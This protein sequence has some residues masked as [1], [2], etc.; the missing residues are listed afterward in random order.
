MSIKVTYIDRTSQSYKNVDMGVEM[1]LGVVKANWK[2][3]QMSRW[4]RFMKFMKQKEVIEKQTLDG[5]NFR[6]SNFDQMNMDNCTE[7]KEPNILNK[8]QQKLSSGIKKRLTMMPRSPFKDDSL[9]QLVQDSEN[10][11]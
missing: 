5:L 2:P 9:Y 1:N 3:I 8:M 4:I 10:D 7:R 6:K 11:D